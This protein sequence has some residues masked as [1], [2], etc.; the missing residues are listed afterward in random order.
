MA[1]A[2]K[3]K[4]ITVITPDKAGMLYQ[5]TSAVARAGVNIMAITAHGAAGNKA[6]FMLV[7]NNNAKAVKALKAKK[8][9][10]K[11]NEAAAVA[12][13]DKVGA[14]SR[15]AQRLARAGVDLDYCYGSTSKRGKALLVFSTKD[16]KRALKVC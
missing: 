8:F 13:A 12:L 2:T 5:V 15:L 4:E 1:N 6:K 9:R 11:Q 14:A 10:V 7:T 16:L 3:V